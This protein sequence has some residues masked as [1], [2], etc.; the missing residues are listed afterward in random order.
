MEVAKVQM[1]IRDDLAKREQTE[2][3]E[4]A[5]IEELHREIL[6]LSTLFNRF[7]RPFKLYEACLDALR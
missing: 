6:P 3:A 4:K 2:S 5:A 7:A 1:R